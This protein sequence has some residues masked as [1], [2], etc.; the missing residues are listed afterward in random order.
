MKIISESFKVCS[1]GN[2]PTFHTVTEKVKGILAKSNIKSG[3]CVVYSRHTTCAVM[4]DENSID[5]SY[6]GL[7]YLQQDLTD[8][9]EKIIPRCRKEGQYMHPGPELTVFSAQ[10]G[11]DKPGTL[12]T[13]AHLRSSIMGRSET[14]PII[15]G[16][17]ELGEFGHVYFVDFDHTRGRERQV[18]V[19]ILGE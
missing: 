2:R 19:Q 15:N 13:D 5:E 10:H 6:T 8:V 17:L 16:D 12:N 14:I 7:T 1:T 3:I 18:I 4:I 11:E 9:F